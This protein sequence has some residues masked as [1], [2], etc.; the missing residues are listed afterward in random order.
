MMSICTIFLIDTFLT[1]VSL[2]SQI[3]FF[4]SDH[5]S[6]YM[7]SILCVNYLWCRQFPQIPILGVNASV[8]VDKVFMKKISLYFRHDFAKIL[9]ERVENWLIVKQEIVISAGNLRDWK[10]YFFELCWEFRIKNCA[11]TA[12]NKILILPLSFSR[13]KCNLRCI[14][15]H[16]RFII[17][18]KVC[19]NFFLWVEQNRRKQENFKKHSKTTFLSSREKANIFP[20][21]LFFADFY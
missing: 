19:E 2:Q 5:D 21:F 3:E 17:N 16:T 20:P 9:N 10:Q 7:R 18:K 15:T 4:L 11:E 8:C 1:N 13:L 6:W 12:I 14:Q